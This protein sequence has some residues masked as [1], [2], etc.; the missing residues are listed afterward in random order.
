MLPQPFQVIRRRNNNLTPKGIT[1]LFFIFYPPT[2]LI[3]FWII[4]IG[5][6]KRTYHMVYVYVYLYYY[7]YT[8]SPLVNVCPHPH[9]ACAFGLVKT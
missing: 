7:F 4:I 3:H 6:S 5:I 1:F 2:I 9:E 8:S